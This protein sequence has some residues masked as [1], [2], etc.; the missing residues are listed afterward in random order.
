MLAVVDNQKNP[1]DL[2]E[3]DH[4][5]TKRATS[6]LTQPQRRR[7][8]RD[9]RLRVRQPGELT[10]IHAVRVREARSRSGDVQRETGLSHPRRAR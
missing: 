5:V 6:A 7:H 1:L 10:Q 9:D 3:L 8:S 4:A 2:Q